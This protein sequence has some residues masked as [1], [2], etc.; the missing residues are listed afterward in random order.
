MTVRVVYTIAVAISSTSAGEKDLGNPSFKVTCDTQ[1]EGGAQKTTLAAGATDVALSLGNISSA[2]FLLIKTNSKDPTLA[3]PVISIKKDS[4]GGE[5]LPVAPLSGAKEAHMLLT[6]S[7][8]TALYA[9]NPSSTVAV[10]VTVLAA[11]D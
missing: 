4:T 1:G 5:A 6:T 9:T 10:E 11:G 7:G 8:I 3:L 2:K